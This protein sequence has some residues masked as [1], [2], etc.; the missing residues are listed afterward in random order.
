MPDRK[1]TSRGSGGSGASL[2]QLQGPA[3][4]EPFTIIKELTME[5]LSIFQCLSDLHTA[6]AN[7]NE[8]VL[9][10]SS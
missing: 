8:S 4:P 2:A 6:K 1:R 3:R 5:N 7:T 9:R 10:A